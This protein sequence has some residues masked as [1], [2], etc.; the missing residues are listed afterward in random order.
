MPGKKVVEKYFLQSSY[1]HFFIIINQFPG[2]KNAE[3]ELIMRIELYCK[4]YNIDFITIN[5]NGKI[6]VKLFLGSS[7]GSEIEMIQ[8]VQRGERLQG[9][10]FSTG[11]VGSALEVPILEMIELPYLFKNN[12]EADVILDE[13]LYTP[14]Q[15]ALDEKGI[16]FYSWSE[17][18]WRNFATKGGAATSPE[19]FSTRDPVGC[20]SWQNQ[21]RNT[22]GLWLAYV[23]ASP[24][25]PQVQC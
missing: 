11:A 16:T 17:N 10:G 2:L 18:G 9:G 22:L 23:S 15:K 21:L 1:K 12:N 14:T 13:I 5:S 19:D 7:L 6:Q 4:E 3:A 8:D 20:H 24:P 25:F